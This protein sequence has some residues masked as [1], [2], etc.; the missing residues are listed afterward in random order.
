MKHCQAKTTI[1]RDLKWRHRLKVISGLLEQGLAVGETARRVGLSGGWVK[2]LARV[3]GL[4]GPAGAGG[5]PLYQRRTGML[6]F[7]RDFIAKCSYPSTIR[8][9]TGVC[10]ISSASATDC[11]LRLLEHGSCLTRK[12]GPARNIA[13]IG[14]GRSRLPPVPGSSIRE[15]GA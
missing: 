10:H 12:P 11:N 15:D 1:Y 14:Q 5:P 13:L 7:I 2:R 9:I 4:T 6:A 3:Y 8:E